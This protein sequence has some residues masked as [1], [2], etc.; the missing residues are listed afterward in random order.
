MLAVHLGEALLA[1]A[2][3]SEVGSL[4][5][6]ESKQDPLIRNPR[7]SGAPGTQLTIHDKIN[8][9]SYST[10]GVHPRP[11]YRKPPGLN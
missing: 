5:I 9:S 3:D 7:M 10:D 8:P 4:P 1:T 11:T 2:V 6:P